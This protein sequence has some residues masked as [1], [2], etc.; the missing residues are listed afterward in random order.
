MTLVLG[1]GTNFAQDHT[2]EWL[3]E[4][5]HDR[6]TKNVGEASAKSFDALQVEHIKDYQSLFN[7]FTLSLGQTAPELLTKTTAERLRAYTEDK[8][9]D[10]EIEALFCQ[11]GRYLL[12]SCSRPGALPAN[13]QGVWNNSNLPVWAGDYHS[14]INLEMNYW[15]VETANIAECHVPLIDYID[16]I[17]EAV[18]YTHLTLPT[19]A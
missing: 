2:K 16:S 1:A 14:N 17:R 3:G 18:S 8:T 5:P 12:I 11:F 9:S 15:P 7:R 10:P 6:V 4:H 19:K 13:L